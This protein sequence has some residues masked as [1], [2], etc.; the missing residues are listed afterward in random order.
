MSY[1]EESDWSDS[2][3]GNDQLQTSVLL[4]LPDGEIVDPKDLR[5]PNVSRLG[6]KPVRSCAY[7]LEYRQYVLTH[8]WK[9]CFYMYH[10]SMSMHATGLTDIY[11]GFN[12]S[13]EGTSVL[14]PE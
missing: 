11:A 4:G 8:I 13:G 10:I 6:G 1:D 14:F 2:E 5:D 9:F 12:S 3:E 7:S